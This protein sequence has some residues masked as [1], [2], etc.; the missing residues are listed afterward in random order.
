MKLYYKNLILVIVVIVASTVCVS[1]V[2][3]YRL[4]KQDLI[5]KCELEKA[6]IN[7][8]AGIKGN[9]GKFFNVSPVKDIDCNSYR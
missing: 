3:I 6:R 9:S 7:V 1:A 4:Y 8:E 5:K 2:Q